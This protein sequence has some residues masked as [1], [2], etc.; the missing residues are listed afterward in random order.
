V[1]IQG[2]PS[3]PRVLDWGLADWCREPWVAVEG[4]GNGVESDQFVVG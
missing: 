3:E 4:S 2:G 1:S